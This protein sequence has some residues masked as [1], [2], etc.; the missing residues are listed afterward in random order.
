MTTIRVA[1]EH[2]PEGG[3]AADYLCRSVADVRTLDLPWPWSET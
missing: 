3:T 2:E 1:I